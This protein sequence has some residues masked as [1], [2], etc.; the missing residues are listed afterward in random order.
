LDGTALASP[1]VTL[2]ALAVVA[3][4]ARPAVVISDRARAF[5]GTV[6]ILFHAHSILAVLCAFE[7][8]NVEQILVVQLGSERIAPNSGGGCKLQFVQPSEVTPS[9]RLHDKWAGLVCDNDK[10]HCGTQREEHVK[11]ALAND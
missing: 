4:L 2:L 11:K 9:A 10:I 8:G 6:R 3:R 1:I 5:P 7:L